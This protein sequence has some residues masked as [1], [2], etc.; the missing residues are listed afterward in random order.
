MASL[1]RAVS[2]TD[3][4]KTVTGLLEQGLSSGHVQ[5]EELTH[6]SLLNQTRMNRIEKTVKADPGIVVELN[7]LR[8]KYTWLVISEGW[9][10]D[11]AQIVPVINTL[12]ELV[13]A[14]DLKILFRDDNPE[15]MDLFLTNGSRS[16]P[17]LIVLDSE[18]KVLGH[19]GPRP[20]GAVDLIAR[21]KAQKGVVDEEA[22]TELQLWYLHDKGLSTQ[23]ELARL[24][25]EIGAKN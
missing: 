5:S 18:G 14:I 6:Y 21:H 15:I 24:M 3:Y 19:W 4:R 20:Q 7:S 12:A 8:G 9:C 25:A 11:A 23:Q 22:K 13:P 1:A 16:I 2:Y 17:K 10:G